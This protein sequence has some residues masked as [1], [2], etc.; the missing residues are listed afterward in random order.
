MRIYNTLTHK[1]EIFIPIDEKEVKFY[2]CGPTVYDYFHIGN[3]RSFV[4]ADM[5]RKYLE[6][7][8]Y[9]VKFVMNITDVDDKI[10]RRS[11]DEHISSE[12]VGKKY[13]DAFLNDIERLRIKKADVY[14][15]ATVHM[16]EMVNLIAKLEKSG[17][18]YNVDGNVFY[19]V[20][21]FDGYGK[22]SGKNIDDL[23]AGS[24]N[25]VNDRKENQMD[26]SLW[27]KAKENEPSWESPWGNGRP[28]WHTECAA[29]SRKHL[30]ET[31]D[32]HAGGSDLIFPHHENEIAQSEAA[33]GKPFVKD[34]LH[35]GFLNIREEK[36]SKS[37]GNFFTAREILDQ[38]PAETIRLFFAQAHYRAPLNFSS[39]LLAASNSG[40]DKL[41][42]L[43][44]MIEEKKQLALQDSSEPDTIDFAEFYKRFNVA[45]DDDFNTPQATAVIF[46]FTRVVNKHLAE[47]DFVSI[48]FL[49]KSE[50]FL[51]E[52]ADGI[53]GIVD[54][55]CRDK[56][57]SLEP[58]LIQILIDL[59]QQA[60]EQKN[61]ALSDEIRNKLNDAGVELKD[62]KDGTTYKLK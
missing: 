13:A 31:I 7:A 24:R 51:R 61:Y 44:E 50:S 18:A 39:E 52:T 6:Y 41:K 23:I 40:V 28:G 16:D 60:R 45:M 8:G 47:S 48:S 62:S 56:T 14:P 54:M 21:K 9:N 57:K 42:N 15:R 29:M 26:F 59:R 10:I 17:F 25:E 38:Y 11:I 32:I 3:A 34:W 20:K 43:A 55:S 22:L 37:L 46:D 33:S 5:L 1:K 36:M 35:F 4:M 53:L 58:Q 30:G 49:E 2:V 19:N 27:K 12:V